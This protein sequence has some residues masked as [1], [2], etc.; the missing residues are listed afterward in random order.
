VRDYRLIR[1]NL[2]QSDGGRRGQEGGGEGGLDERADILN[3]AVA[4]DDSSA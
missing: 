3:T 2:S 1:P 4:V